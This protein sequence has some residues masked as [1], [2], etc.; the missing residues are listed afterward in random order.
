MKVPQK[1]PCKSAPQS[2]PAQLYLTS[3]SRSP[4]AIWSEIQR[5]APARDKINMM[6]VFYDCLDSTESDGDAWVVGHSLIRSVTKEDAH[7]SETG[8]AW[9]LRQ[10][11]TEMI[12]A[13]GASTIWHGLQHAVRAFLIQEHDSK[14]LQHLLD[15]DQEHEALQVKS[16]INS[17]AHWLALRAS[18]RD[19]LPLIIQAGMFLRI[20]GF[21]SFPSTEDIGQRMFA[22]TLPF[23]YTSWCKALPRA[24]ENVKGLIDAELDFM[25]ESLSMNKESLAQTIRS[26]YKDCPPEQAEVQHK[27]SVCSDD[28]VNLGTGLV[29]PRRISFNECR[30]AN[31]KPECLCAEYLCAQ[32]VTQGPPT[33]DIGDIDDN[34][35]DEE[36]FQD[37][38]DDVQQLCEA[39]DR[40]GVEETEGDYFHEA[41][42]LLYR[43]QG[44]RWVGSYE[45][46][47]LLCS[48]CFLKREC[49]IGEN[50]PEDRHHFTAMPDTYC[51]ASPEYLT[52]T[53]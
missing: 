52:A 10:K 45:P 51:V 16:Q 2:L 26:A 28:Y 3:S 53:F 40:L 29:Q 13:F 12:V 38:D 20:D 5:E 17:I 35:V 42:T 48:S 9:L 21:D 49:Y 6:R 14:L 27:C 24:M 11:Q 4:I 37:T 47:E 50:G 36:Y 30:I 19:L 39:Y 46:L 43:A 18:E 23:L 1:K 22:R 25:L 33:A 8:V 34:D 41:A 15:L 32:G 44:R 31:H 7:M